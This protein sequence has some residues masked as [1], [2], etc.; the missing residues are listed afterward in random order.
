VPGNAKFLSV[1]DHITQNTNN[2]NTS[3]NSARS[4]INREYSQAGEW[5]LANEKFLRW[6]NGTTIDDSRAWLQGDMGTGKTIIMSTIVKHFEYESST[7]PPFG[8][9]FCSKVD[10]RA[11]QDQLT[12]FRSILRQ[13]TRSHM[14]LEFIY[15]EAEARRPRIIGNRDT[16]K[17]QAS[18]EDKDVQDI[19][20][21]YILH[22]TRRTF[23]VFDALDELEVDCTELIYRLD[24]LIDQCKGNCRVMISGRPGIGSSYEKLES[25]WRLI[26]VSQNGHQDMER[27]ITGRLESSIFS[28][29]GVTDEIKRVISE[30]YLRRAGGM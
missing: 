30:S 15:G 6:K 16:W 18:L 27:F 21:K 10:T 1:T 24:E 2:P 17:D 28:R 7:K 4:K 29:T 3:L 9:F 22:N 12:I 23:L 14:G 13:L 20:V 19:L 8:F 5:I 26:Q 11:K 25:D